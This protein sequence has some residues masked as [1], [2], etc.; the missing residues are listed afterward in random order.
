MGEQLASGQCITKVAVVARPLA[1]FKEEV[2]EER[3]GYERH[4][5]NQPEPVSGPEHTQ[6]HTHGLSE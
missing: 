2:R 3:S 4:L 6:T 1:V 5:I